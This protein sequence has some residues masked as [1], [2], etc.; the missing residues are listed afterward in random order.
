M[1]LGIGVA[2]GCDEVYITE[3]LDLVEK[4]R[5]LPL[6]FMRDWRA[7]QREGTKCL[8]NPWNDDG[9]LVDLD[10]YPKLKGYLGKNEER[11]RRRRVARDHPDA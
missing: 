9:T 6:F 11:L 3:D 8:V 1:R 7:G 2:S 4:D 5:M 10:D